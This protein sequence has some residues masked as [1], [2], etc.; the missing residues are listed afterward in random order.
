MPVSADVSCPTG[1]SL[2]GWLNYYYSSVQ[3]CHSVS[4]VYP[5]TGS[6]KAGSRLVHCFA[7][8][9]IPSI[10]CC[11]CKNGA[12]AAFRDYNTGNSD[13]PGAHFVACPEEDYC[14]TERVRMA[15]ERE[16]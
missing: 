14:C 1:C 5:N 11:D 10:S 8:M 7:I 4:F 6:L 16:W 13:L 2:S 15:V 12:G 9:S 3:N